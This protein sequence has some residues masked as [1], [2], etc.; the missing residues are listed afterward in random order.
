MANPFDDDTPKHGGIR[1]TNP[2]ADDNDNS[3]STSIGGGYNIAPNK[4]QTQQS[5]SSSSYATS[6]ASAMN[7][8]SMS[9]SSFNLTDPSN[10]ANN[11]I[12]ETE[13]SW[14]DLGM[15]IFCVHI[16]CVVCTL[17]C[18]LIISITNTHILHYII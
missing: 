16:M 12:D 5:S 18:S 1:S 17:F 4:Q 15:L 2:F 3:P 11:D 10:S 9:R 6:S 13:S 8:G 7:Q 14:Q